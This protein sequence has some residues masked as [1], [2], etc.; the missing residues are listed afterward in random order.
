MRSMSRRTATRKEFAAQ[1][2]DAF[3]AA[4]DDRGKIKVFKDLA[5][6]HPAEA[7]GVVCKAIPLCMQRV[8]TQAG[9]SYGVDIAREGWKEQFKQKQHSDVEA[10]LL[11][12]A[13]NYY[14]VFSGAKRS[15][16]PTPQTSRCLKKWAC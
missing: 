10:G 16:M 1:L 14:L 9:E 12:M 5:R 6:Q 13:A 8:R 15:S 2:D 3:S 4:A 7:A 11:L